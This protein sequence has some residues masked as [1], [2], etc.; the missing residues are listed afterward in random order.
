MAYGGLDGN[1]EAALCR[2]EQ[3]YGIERN[4]KK[5]SFLFEQVCHGIGGTSSAYNILMKTLLYRASYVYLI[6]AFLYGFLNF[7]GTGTHRALSSIL[8][9]TVMAW[10]PVVLLGIPVGVLVLLITAP[11]LSKIIKIWKFV[12]GTLLV[13]IAIPFVLVFN[14]FREVAADDASGFL[15]IP[16]VMLGLPLLMIGVIGLLVSEL[17]EWR[18]SKV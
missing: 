2:R 8:P 13:L 5:L 16:V 17:I 1:I 4:G 15:L 12:L 7:T 10:L 3:P 11:S 9:Y 18:R 6:I 14:P